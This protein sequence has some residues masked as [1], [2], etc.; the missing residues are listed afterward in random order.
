LHENGRRTWGQS[1]VV[2]AWGQVLAQQAKGAGVVLADINKTQLTAQ[3]Q[4]L[5]ALSHRLL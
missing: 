3:R 5:P 1:M 2:D 4:Q